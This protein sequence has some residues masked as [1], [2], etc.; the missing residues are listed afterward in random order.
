MV[1][2]TLCHSFFVFSIFVLASTIPACREK[3]ARLL[4]V[5]SYDDFPSGSGLAVYKDLI[6]VVGDDAID[7]MIVDKNLNA[8]RRIPLFESRGKRIPKD[9]KPDL[10]SVTLLHPEQKGSFLLTGSGSFS[11]SRDSCVI[12]DSAGQQKRYSLSRFYDRLRKAGLPDLN[13]EG[14]AMLPAGILFASRG[15]KTFPK[16]FLVLT[17]DRFWENQ[18]KADIKMI[19]LG[20]ETDTSMFSGVSGLDYSYRTDQLFITLS[21][22]DTRNS[23][24]DGAIGKSYLWIVNEISAKKKWSVINP[25]RII[26]LEELDPRFAGNK[27]ES[28]AVLVPEAG[29]QELILV[30]DDD[31]GGTVL[32][33]LA[34]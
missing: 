28:V 20:G 9:V 31:K 5:K 24:D 30:S 33:R 21:T 25:D 27:I 32:F 23:Y 4:A 15:N 3:N 26:D 29:K 17:N 10:E 16:N 6:Y 2:R 7:I 22:E 14:A 34:L 19:R 1:T 8:T 11:P 12:I 18:E 13:I